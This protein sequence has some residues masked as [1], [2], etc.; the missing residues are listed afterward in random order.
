VRFGSVLSQHPSTDRATGEAIDGLAARMEGHAPDL[1]CL[2]VSAQHE[3]GFL[4]V[5]ERVRRAFPRALVFGCTAQAVLADGREA[6]DSPGVALVGAR[7][8]GVVLVPFHAAGGKLPDLAAPPDAH[9]L[10][11]AEPWSG[12]LD[13]L[14]PALD[15]RFPAGAKIGGVASGARQP[16]RTLLFLGHGAARSGVVAV[17]LHGDVALESVVAQGCRPVGQ[18]LFVTGASGNV[19]TQL[20][21]RPPIEVLRELYEA[22]PP[23]EQALFHHSLFVGLELRTGQ[24]RYEEGDFLIRNLL[25]ADAGTGALHIAAD[26]SGVRVVQFHLRDPAAASAD[27]SRRLARAA[28]ADEPGAGALLFSCLGRGQG[29]YGVPDHDSRAFASAFPRVPLGGFFCNGEVGPVEGRTFL[30]GYTSA[31]GIFRAR[32]TTAG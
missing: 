3:E 30:H 31:F 18:P 15:A 25:G 23:A 22:A 12:E 4:S 11:L 17:A 10:L 19:V 28:R 14:L 16:G 8:P 5:A 6:E 9:V 13:A 20:D 7:L 1:V 21:G 2:F 26:L 27:L 29:L 32:P 24:G